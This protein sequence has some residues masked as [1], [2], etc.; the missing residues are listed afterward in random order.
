LGGIIITTEQIKDIE[1]DIDRDNIET[2]RDLVRISFKVYR[3]CLKK[4]KQKP[5]QK[6]TVNFQSDGRGGSAKKTFEDRLHEVIDADR[7]VKDFRDC[8]SNLSPF[9]VNI[10]MDQHFKELDNIQIYM[11]MRISKSAFYVIQ[12]QAEKALCAELLLKGYDLERVIDMYEYM[13]GKME[14][15]E[16]CH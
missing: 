13:S 16:E 10:F 5:E 3:L 11:K 14:S 6:T 15:E 2:D 8:V 1:K 4:R 12:Q 9:Y 7:Y